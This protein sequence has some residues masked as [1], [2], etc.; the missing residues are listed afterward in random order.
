MKFCKD[1]IHFLPLSEMCNSENSVSS[2]DMIW[3]RHEKMAA[4]EMRNDPGRCGLGAK[5][6]E[7]T[8]GFKKYI[9]EGVME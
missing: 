3:G 4:R 8:N 2:I 7:D 1:C 9:G 5:L 6:F